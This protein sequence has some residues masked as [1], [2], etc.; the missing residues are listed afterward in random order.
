MGARALRSALAAVLLLIFGNGAGLAASADFIHAD[1]KRLVDSHGD[2]F[3]VKGIN[4]GNWLYPEAYMFQ[5]KRRILAPTKIIEAFDRLV[6]PEQGERFWTEF[7]DVYVA[8]E[9]IDFLKVAGFNTVRV[10]MS[11]RLFVEEGNDGATRFEG[12]GWALIDRLVDW[13]RN[14][15]LR[16]IL[17]MHSAPGGQTGHTYDDGTGY[18]LLFYVPQY[19]QLTFALWQKLAARYRDEPTVL[20]YDLLNEPISPFN[21]MSYLNPRLDLFYRDL[22]AAIRRIDPNHAVLLGGAQ[23]DTNF[24]VFGRPFDANAIYTFHKFWFDPNRAAVQEYINYSNQ[25][26]VPVIMGETGEYNDD[27]NAKARKVQEQIGIGWIFW[28]YKNLESTA[29]VTTIRK[30]A[31]WDFV[32]DAASSENAPLPPLQQT[33]SILDAYLQ[34][35]KFKNVQINAGYLRSLGMVVPPET[36]SQ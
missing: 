9:D 33:Q 7:R 28:T 4:L 23:W 26:N 12:P 25:W 14:A 36:N 1:G 19:R 31:G 20:G 30:P 18:P 35:A 2:T 27:W 22:V 13:C 21:D 17:D 34:A 6:G 29:A 10:P 3:A 5:L 11:W 32:A 24:G 16:V 15:G 8:K